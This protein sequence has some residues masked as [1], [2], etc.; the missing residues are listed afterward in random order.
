MGDMIWYIPVSLVSG[1]QWYQTYTLDKVNS[2][3]L[4]PSLLYQTYTLDKV[5]SVGLTPSL[6]NL[7]EIIHRH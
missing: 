6:L 5:N 1:R 7:M 3:G 4:T 2:V